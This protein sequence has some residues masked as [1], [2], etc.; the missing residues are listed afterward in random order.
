MKV[1]EL[2]CLLVEENMDSDIAIQVGNSYEHI[3]GIAPSYSP[4][5][6]YVLL[7]PD[8]PLEGTK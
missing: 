7:V 4:H 5:S 6:G 2:I 8:N 3:D 1:K